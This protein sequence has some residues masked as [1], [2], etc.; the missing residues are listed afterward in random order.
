MAFFWL[1]YLELEYSHDSLLL[2][3]CQLQQSARFLLSQDWN[4]HG[5]FPLVHFI[6]C[7]KRKLFNN[8]YGKNK[9]IPKIILYIKVLCRKINLSGRI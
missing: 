4:L 9:H 7:T 1:I 5:G 8:I 3:M 2:R 6:L